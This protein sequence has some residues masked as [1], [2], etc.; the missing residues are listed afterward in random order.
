MGVYDEEVPET[1]CGAWCLSL[2]YNNGISEFSERADFTFHS[3]LKKKREEKQTNKQKTR[4]ES[5]IK[6]SKDKMNSGRYWICL[7]P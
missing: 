6:K 7:L 5:K 2:K 4:K 3:Y 1:R